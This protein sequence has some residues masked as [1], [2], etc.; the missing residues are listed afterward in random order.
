[1]ERREVI[2]LFGEVPKH[3]Q[4]QP[5]LVRMHVVETGDDCGYYPVGVPAAVRFACR[6]CSEV[7]DW[8]FVMATTAKRGIPCP[9]CNGEKS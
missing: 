1:M 6:Q 5:K 9:K 3:Q 8:M 7:T 2:D 4:R